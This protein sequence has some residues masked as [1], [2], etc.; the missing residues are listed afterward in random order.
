M[1]LITAIIFHAENV[2]RSHLTLQHWSG[3]GLRVKQKYWFW[4]QK[5][6]GNQ[7]K[8]KKIAPRKRVWGAFSY[9]LN[10]P[11]LRDTA[12]LS[13]RYPPILRYGVFGVST[14]PIGCDTPSPFSEHFPFGEHAKWRCD[15]PPPQKGYLSDTCAIPYEKKGQ[16]V[17]YPPL[18]YYL[19]K[20]LRDMGG[21]S[22][23]RHV[24]I[25]RSVVPGM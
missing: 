8:N 13:Q 19:E 5:M 4:P 17:R 12:R 22:H 23:T 7:P 2:F 21:V 20:V 1:S 18:R 24:P 16:W 15:T 14:W 6:G 10:G 9:Y 25:I 11:V 3:S